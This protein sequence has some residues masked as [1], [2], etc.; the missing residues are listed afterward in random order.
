VH[1]S[2]VMPPES[3]DFPAQYAREEPTMQRV[4]YG[5]AAL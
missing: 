1:R 5:S 2:Y 4:G 3:I